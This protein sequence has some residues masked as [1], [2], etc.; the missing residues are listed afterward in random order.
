MLRSADNPGGW[1]LAD[2][3]AQARA[4]LNWQLLAFD[5]RNEKSAQ[6]LSRYQKVVG[7]LYEAEGRLRA[8]PAPETWAG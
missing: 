5:G 7:A 6:V 4:E 2:L 8:L 1:V 3:L